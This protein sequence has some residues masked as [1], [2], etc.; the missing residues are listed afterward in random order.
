MNFG[1]NKEWGA[2]TTSVPEFE[3]FLDVFQE[4][5]YNEVDT[6]R[7]YSGGE[8]EAFTAAAHWKERGL[9]LATKLYPFTPGQHSPENLTRLFNKSLEELQTTSVDIFYLHAPDRSVPINATL[10]TLNTLFKEGK[11]KQ[12]GLSN[13]T[14]FEVAEIV[15]TCKE[16]GWVRPTIYQGM[17]NAITRNIEPELVVACR[18]YGLELVTYNPLAGGLFTGKYKPDSEPLTTESASGSLA[19]NTGV[20]KTYRE[21][22]F[23]DAYFQALKLIEPVVKTQG[24][25][26]VEVGLRWVIHHSALNIVD[27]NDGVII[28]VSTVE[29]LRASIA[30]LEK[31]P[32]PQEVLDVLDQAWKITRFEA[33]NYWHLD[34]EYGYGF[35]EQ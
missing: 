8:Q 31:G 26:L 3:K 1:P 24:L 28:G 21:R 12:L 18:R 15:T 10:Q 20:G 30:D 6:A 4:L 29:Q 25:T 9:K 2:R 11:F 22:Y 34:L 13:F 5:G 23:K 7:T 27:G 14:A 33:P 16:R 17:Y 32:L 19:A 35:D